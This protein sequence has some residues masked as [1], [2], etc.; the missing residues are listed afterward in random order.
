MTTRH[1][2]HHLISNAQ[3]RSHCIPTTYFTD[4]NVL[5]PVTLLWHS[6]LTLP[7]RFQTHLAS[8]SAPLLPPLPQLVPVLSP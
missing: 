1:L 8:S 7:R 5:S 3:P 2:K 4:S 6:L